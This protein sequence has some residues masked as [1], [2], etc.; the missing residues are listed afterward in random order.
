MYQDIVRL[1]KS[2]VMWGPTRLCEVAD[3]GPG[4]VFGVWCK[5]VARNLLLIC[6]GVN[7]R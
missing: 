4:V 2:N 7:N 3:S 1:K 6:R 5:S